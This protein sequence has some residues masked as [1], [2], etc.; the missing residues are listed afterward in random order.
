M[1]SQPEDFGLE[2]PADLKHAVPKR[3]AEYLAGRWCLAR[4]YAQAGIDSPL[5]AHQQHGPPQWPPDWTASITHSRDRAAAALA[6][7]Q[8]VRALG[9]D[10]EFVMRPD[11]A[12][13]VRKAILRPAE[14]HLAGEILTLTLIFSFKESLYKALNPLLGRFIG[15]DEA[16]VVRIDTSQLHFEPRGE[17]QNDFPATAPLRAGWAREGEMLITGYEWPV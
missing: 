5:P 9:L 6:P 8:A 11:T 15:F 4:L 17:L 14:E 13:R 1:P 10:L 2:L 3:Q 16:E 7:T 12:A